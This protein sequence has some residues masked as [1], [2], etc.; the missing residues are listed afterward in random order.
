MI[1]HKRIPSREGGVEIVVDELSTRMVKLG[2]RVDA[3][4]RSGY[5]VSGKEFD[6]KRGKI[7]EGVRLITIPTFRN[8]K[9]NAIV[10][11]FLATIVATAKA[12]FGRYDVIH[13]HAEGPCIMLWLPK[14]FG[15]R[16]IATI[17]GLDW[18]RSK[19]E[20]SRPKC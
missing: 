6:E 16:V 17:H 2:N 10:Y 11:S 18:Q 1:G 19:W 14:L 13:F 20:I 9:L 7:Y 3:Y 12:I 4:N 15:I 5:H 8:S